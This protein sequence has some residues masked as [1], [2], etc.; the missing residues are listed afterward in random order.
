MHEN[1]TLVSPFLD[2]K[3]E[4][5]DPYNEKD[6]GEKAKEWL[7]GLK[8]RVLDTE[9]KAKAFE[10]GKAQILD[11]KESPDESQIG[12]CMH[13]MLFNGNVTEDQT[14][15]CLA[16]ALE[17]IMQMEEKMKQM[18]GQIMDQNLRI[19][20]LTVE[21]LNRIQDSVKG[22]Q[23]KEEMAQRIKNLKAETWGNEAVMEENNILREQVKMLQK[24]IKDW[25]AEEF[26][27]KEEGG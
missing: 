14:I 10:K 15:F 25:T 5:M 22:E 19:S 21:N 17:I 8:R 20:T 6:W 7:Y 27:W 16:L 23:E 13:T 4:I 12:K 24:L 18:Q 1:F 26:W 9:E 11:C 2:D 3:G